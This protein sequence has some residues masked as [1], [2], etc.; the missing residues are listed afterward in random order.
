[1]RQNGKCSSQNSESTGRL[2]WEQCT[3]SMATSFSSRHITLRR[4]T[5]RPVASTCGLR[6][7]T[8]QKCQG[9]LHQC[10][11][12]PELTLS[13][14]D[15]GHDLSSRPGRAFVAKSQHHSPPTTSKHISSKS[16]SQLKPS[17]TSGSGP[18]TFRVGQAQGL[19]VLESTAAAAHRTRRPVAI[20]LPGELPIGGLRG[21]QGQRELVVDASTRLSSS[22]HYL[23]AQTRHKQTPSQ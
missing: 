12:Q 22:D 2:R 8:G 16:L 14:S 5:G 9:P 3:S 13:S 21:H 17:A 6:Q 15:S 19:L 4:R 11:E 18:L 20:Q 23:Q 10:T 1:M 7:V